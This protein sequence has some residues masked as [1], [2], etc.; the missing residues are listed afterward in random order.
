MGNGGF[1]LR[2]VVGRDV[3][4]T[5]P[6]SRVGDGI[7]EPRPR[8]DCNR[9]ELERECEEVGNGGEKKEKKGFERKFEKQE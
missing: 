4:G 9:V 1:R 8:H 5:T 7:G 3:G 2:T 6:A